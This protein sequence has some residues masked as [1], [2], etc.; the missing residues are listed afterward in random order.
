[1]ATQ[2]TLDKQKMIGGI[3]GI[4]IVS[5]I[6][7]YIAGAHLG[8][9]KAV[10]GRPGAGAF[11]Q[12]GGQTGVRAG[13]GARTNFGSGGVASGEII[14]KDA[15][16]ITIKLRDGGSRIIFLS[17]TST[18]AKSESGT[19]A[20]LATGQ[21]VTVMG[22]ANSDGSIMAQSVQIRPAGSLPQGAP[23][24]GTAMPSVPPAQQ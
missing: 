4:V 13:A 3:V 10:I 17:G 24:G 15:T 19:A 11:G 18:I 12:F 14:S 6:V 20:D 23:T 7:G 2:I 16:S 1:M 8:K 9:S 22:T 5:L 21:Q